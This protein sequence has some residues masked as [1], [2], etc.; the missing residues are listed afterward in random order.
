MIDCLLAH[1]GCCA[2]IKTRGGNL[3][4]PLIYI[5]SNQCLFKIMYIMQQVIFTD[6]YKYPKYRCAFRQYPQYWMQTN[7]NHRKAKERDSFM[8][9][10]V[11]EK[12]PLSTIQEQY[13]QGPQGVKAHFP[14][15]LP[16]LL[17]PHLLIPCLF[18]KTIQN[19]R[20]EAYISF[21]LIPKNYTPKDFT[22]AVLSMKMLFKLPFPPLLSPFPP[23]ICTDASS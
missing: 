13:Y 8:S 12:A 18:A 23:L 16:W 1:N 22:L 19:T 6:I 3:D 4:R 5:P 17:L 21:V 2:A 11:T 10:T 20:K 7:I 15:C 14:L 9:T